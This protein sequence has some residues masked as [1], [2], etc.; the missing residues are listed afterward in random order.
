MI[1]FPSFHQLLRTIIYIYTRTNPTQQSII[2]T[3]KWNNHKNLRQRNVTNL[4]I[5]QISSI[6]LTFCEA[7]R[8]ISILLIFKT[9]EM[10]LSHVTKKKSLVLRDVENR[11]FI[12]FF[13]SPIIIR[14]YIWQICK[15]NKINVVIKP[16]CKG[17]NVINFSALFSLVCT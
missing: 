8:F 1:W 6:L 4:E 17:L 13:T 14:F 15:K 3:K 7:P 11:R 16:D 5:Y 10:S 12:S 2:I 9:S